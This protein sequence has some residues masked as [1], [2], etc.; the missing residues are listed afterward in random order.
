MFFYKL[1]QSFKG[2][3]KYKAEKNDTINC[4]GHSFHQTM[5]C[6]SITKPIF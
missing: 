2:K 5:C 1:I 3:T 6:M 4:D